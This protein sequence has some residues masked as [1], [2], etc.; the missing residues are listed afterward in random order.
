[1]TA[2]DGLVRVEQGADGVVQ[3]VLDAPPVTMFSVELAAALSAVVDDLRTTTARAVVIT[4]VEGRFSAGGD[5]RRFESVRDRATA[6]RFVRE[7][8]DLFDRV[9]A[10]PA[11]TIAAI[12]GYALGGGLE[13][14]LACDIRV[15]APDAQLGLPESRWGLLAGAGGTQRLARAVGPGAAKLLMCTAAPVDGN[16]A[17]RLHLV[18]RVAED[19]LAEAL[20]I[21]RQIAG[22]SPAAV[23]R[24]KR[25][26]DEGLGLPLTAALEREAEHWADLIPIGDHLEGAAAFFERRAPRYPDAG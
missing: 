7:A 26:V 6:H 13:L 12:D 24:I 19:P 16:E 3:V 17:L 11:P 15:A 21:A 1:M 25:C 20:T 10:I 2:R 9:A 22:N 23:R 4:G 18:D 5:I 14:A 8:Q